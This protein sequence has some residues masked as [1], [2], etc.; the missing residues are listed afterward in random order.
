MTT[1]TTTRATTQTTH[2]AVLDPTHE[3]TRLARKTMTCAASGR[4]VA[5][6]TEAKHSSLLGPTP[7]A[8]ATQTKHSKKQEK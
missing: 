5:A 1:A 7:G 3:G 6:T 2:S 4:G 8:T